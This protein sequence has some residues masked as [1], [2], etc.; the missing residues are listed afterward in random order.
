MRADKIAC[1]AFSVPGYAMMQRACRSLSEMIGRHPRLWG[2]LA[3][4]PTLPPRIPSA[5]FVVMSGIRPNR[6]GCP[7]SSAKWLRSQASMAE[8]Q[9]CRAV[10]R[11]ALA[12]VK[13]LETSSEPEP[14]PRS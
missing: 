12:A 1:R 14:M 5:A 11:Y 9:H 6:T 7:A 13:E 2:L 4:K 3:G 8:R 10:R